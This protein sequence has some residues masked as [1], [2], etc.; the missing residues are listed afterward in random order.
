MTNKISGTPEGPSGGKGILHWLVTHHVPA[1]IWLLGVLLLGL[2][3]I[4]SMTRESLPDLPI[5]QALISVEWDGAPPEVVEEEITR[6]LEEEIRGI[7]GMRRYS[8]GSMHSLSMVAVEFEAGIPLEEA[9]QRLRSAVASGESRLPKK[10]EKPHIDQIR[11]R[12]IPIGFFALSG[13]SG[14]LEISRTARDMQKELEEIPGIRR[15]TVE[16]IPRESL[17]VELFPERLE[18]LHLSPEIII[19][20]L[21]ARKHD[22]PLGQFDSPRQ[23]FSLVLE[24]A[25]DD[26]DDLRRMPLLPGKDEEHPILLGDMANLRRAPEKSAVHAKLSVQGGPFREVALLALYMMPG[27]DTSELME[28]ALGVFKKA[29]GEGSIPRKVDW[30][31]IANDAEYIEQELTRGLSNMWQSMAIVFICLLLLL[32]WREALVAALGIPLTIVASLGTLWLTGYTVNTLVL[33]GVI[34]ALGMLVDDFILVM[35]G[36]HHFLT[37]EKQS[38]SEAAWNTLV[39]YGAP[40]FSGSI[41]TI[42]VMVPLCF[43]GGVDGS[44]IRIIPVT[45]AICLSLS[46]LL[47]LFVGIPLSQLAFRRKASAEIS[48]DLSKADRITR[49]AELLLH[50]LLAEKMLSTPLRRGMALTGVLL[51][52]LGGMFLFF[53]TPSTLYPRED[54]K[55]MGITLE[56]PENSTLRDADRIAALAGTLLAEKTYFASIIS[57]AGNRDP[58]LSGTLGEMLTQETSPRFVGFACQLT[59]RKNRE[60]EGFHYAEDLRK[61][62]AKL[63][64]REAGVEVTVTP[65]IG[66]STPE[67]PLQ[68]LLY[69]E[70]LHTLK[71][72]A[73]QVKEPFQ[74]LETIHNLRDSLGYPEK[75]YRF[76]PHRESLQE[77]ALREESLGIQIQVLTSSLKAGDFRQSGNEESLPLY[78]STLWEGMED[79]NSGPV[80]WEQFTGLRLVNDHGETLPLQHVGSFEYRQTYPSILHRNGK[81]CVIVKAHTEG[82]TPGEVLKKVLPTLEKMRATWP[83]GYFYEV[84]GELEQAQ[85]TYRG[86]LKALGLSFF[87]V[88]AILALLFRSLVQPIIILGAVVPGIS[89]VLWGF[90]ALNLPFTFVAAVGLISL[91]GITVNDAI[92][93]V[94]TMNRHRRRGEELK[95]SA[96]R[97][98]SDRLRPVISTTLTTVLALIPLLGESAWQPLGLAI[99]LGESFSTPICLF[100]IPGL[101]ILLSP[102][103]KAPQAC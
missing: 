68:I 71:S 103:H 88:Y 2:M 86:V 49:K 15:V 64:E 98:A 100:L 75:Q 42:L 47:S 77:Y 13:T 73:R 101:Y 5:P 63:L 56:L 33:A 10:A 90:W 79:A 11:V 27:R 97:G 35:E 36:M 32:A 46:Y 60:K 34:L 95:K 25:L 6:P 80:T 52:F 30:T 51:F 17:R 91:V 3:G 21:E 87:L 84:G 54:G 92:V 83:Q 16:G 62:L 89:G 18:A 102:S 93:M 67:A 74:K 14:R 8:S 76:V 70:D 85:A 50:R 57:L 43:I 41:T 7:R 94:D 65:E 29:A 59:P 26:L 82:A 31:L 24:K 12:D 39:T 58:I 28:K 44:F 61:E 23:S 9:M 37:L 40:S 1:S 99:I 96:F 78:V 20:N 4:F 38:F 19:Q 81:R 69:G 48:S 45:T 53:L 72:L 66:G 55:S 22:A